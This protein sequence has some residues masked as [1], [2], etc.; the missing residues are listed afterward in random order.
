MTN[1]ALGIARATSSAR[2]GF[3]TPV[4]R[5]IQPMIGWPLSVNPQFFNA[6]VR[7]VIFSATTPGAM[8]MYCPLAPMWCCS[9]SW[10]TIS[11]TVT[12][13][14]DFF[15]SIFSIA[16]ITFDFNPENSGSSKR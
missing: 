5:A 10:P 14:A 1:C 7:S 15:A 4:T 2:I 3:L 6:S 8:L 13:L 12:N 9:N 16:I 11:P